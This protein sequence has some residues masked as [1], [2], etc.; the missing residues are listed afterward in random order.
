MRLHAVSTPYHPRYKHSPEMAPGFLVEDPD[1]SPFE[2]T[3]HG[4]ELL[5]ARL[6]FTDT[7]RNILTPVQQLVAAAAMTGIRSAIAGR[8]I[9]IGQDSANREMSA[10]C[11]IIGEQTDSRTTSGNFLRRLATSNGVLAYIEDSMPREYCLDKLSRTELAIL[12]G[13]SAD[14][15]YDQI[16]RMLADRG[17]AVSQSSYDVLTA[18][19]IPGYEKNLQSKIGL[20]GRPLLSAAY[21]LSVTE[22][23]GPM[24]APPIP[25]L[26]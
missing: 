19:D 7:Y 13:L 23:N 2:S 18:A 24:Q 16:Q 20:A 9:A 21:I 15:S 25:S 10:A 22:Y 3:V 1:R 4:V 26:F 14:L 17:V 5:E 8:S 6:V 11:R 12:N